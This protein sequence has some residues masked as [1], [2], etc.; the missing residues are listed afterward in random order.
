MSKNLNYSQEETTAFLNLI[1]KHLPIGSEEW[2]VVASEHKE[3][4][5]VQ[6]RTDDSLK[7]KFASFYRSKVPTGDPNCPPHVRRAKH[8]RYQIKERSEIDGP[9]EMITKNSL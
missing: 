8:L 7:R 2:E 4:F 9:C 3:N 5:P 1:E 6:N